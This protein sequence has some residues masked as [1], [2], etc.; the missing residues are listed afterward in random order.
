MISSKRQIIAIAAVLAGF[1]I[2][3]SADVDWFASELVSS[4][5]LGPAPYDNPQ[6]VLGK[7]TQKFKEPNGNIFSSSLVA[8]P[9]N[10]GVADENIIVTINTGGEL[11][12]GFAGPI[13]DDPNNW[14]G[15]DFI[16]FGNSRFNGASSQY[17]TPTTDMASY[18]LSYSGSVYGEKST[19]SVSQYPDGP[20]YTYTNGPFADDYAPTQAYAWD[21]VNHTWGPEM[22]F[23]KPV[24]PALTPASFGNKYAAQGIDLYKSSGGGTAFDISGF[25]LPVNANGRKWIKYIKITG[26]SGEVDAFARVG[27]KIDPV[28]VAQAKRLPDGSRVIL[29]G[30]V[31]SAGTPEMGDCCYIESTDR[32]SGVKVLG[33]NLERRCKVTLEGVMDTSDGERVIRSTTASVDQ[34][35]NIF[36]LG[37]NGKSISAKGMKTTGLLI[38]TWGRVGNV[39]QSAHTFTIDDGS[40]SPIICVAPINQNFT[41]PADTKIVSVTGISTYYQAAGGHLVT[42]LRMRDSSDLQ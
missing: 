21:Y 36:P 39:D 26:N 17:L 34:Q 12:A 6:A 7:P 38:R 16:I 31:V 4:S 42:A 25:D 8:S 20:W 40:G 2:C 1:S 9:W 11:I 15:K 3:A 37:V 28:S 23:T 30:P 14:Y 33:R 5:G 32:S 10:F 41:L 22:D 24:D 13:E 18:K 29:A 27:H 35:E 19:V